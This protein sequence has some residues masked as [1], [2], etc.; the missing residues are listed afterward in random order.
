MP[1]P[2]A[3]IW[4]FFGMDMSLVP[5]DHIDLDRLYKDR[6]LPH[7]QSLFMRGKD[8][9]SAAEPGAF[10][11][12]VESYESILSASLLKGQP[13]IGPRASATIVSVYCRDPRGQRDE[14][15]L[16]QEAR[17]V[18]ELTLENLVSQYRERFELL[19]MLAGKF[20]HAVCLLREVERNIE[21]EH[22]F[23]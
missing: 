19:V 11:R 9:A 6:L 20:E 13:W 17:Q 1:S 18:G 23:S 2:P 7:P 22:P 14:G 3:I 4:Q 5:L 15:R 10:R 16:F 8:P 12:C 21:D